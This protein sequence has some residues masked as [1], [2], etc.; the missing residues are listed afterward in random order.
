[1]KA[2]PVLLFVFT[3]S[4]AG[5]EFVVAPGGPY[6]TVQSAVDAAPPHSVVHIRP[7]VYKERVVVPYEKPHLTFRGDDAAGTII[8]FDSHAGLPGP[9]GPI[10]TFATPT[11]FVQADDF[12][13]ENL[14]FENSAG[15]V[16]QAVALTIMGDRGVFRNCRFLGYQDTLLAQ[17]GRQLFDRCYIAG[18]VDFIFGGS[19]AWFER[20]TIHATAGGYLT[21]ANTTRDQPYGFVFN[22]CKITG[23]PGAKTWL[24]RP[25]RPYAATVFFNSEISDVL[26]PEGW[27]NWNDPAREKTVR[28][29]EYPAPATRVPW[30]KA[31]S[32]EEAARFTIES[33]LSGIDG[34]NPQTGAVRHALRI[35][36]SR[37]AHPPQPPPYR[38]VAAGPDG[39]FHAV[40]TDGKRLLH[41]VSRDL[42][43]WSAPQPVDLM[44]GRDALDLQFPNLFY[45]ESAR[46]FIV[47]WSCTLARNAI[48]AF[49]EDVEANPRIWYATTRDFSTYSETALLFDNNYAVAEARILKLVNGYALLHTDSTWPMQNLRVAFGPSPTGPWGPSTGAFTPKGTRAPLAVQ[50]D[51]T[52]WIFHSGGLLETRDFWTF[53]A[54]PDAV[55]PNIENLSL[56]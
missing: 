33:V 21:A 45:D 30:A 50:R 17:A 23:A 42:K 27:N 56:R 53:T 47:T 31:L 11:V 6:P 46:R 32:P 54:H 52:W 36:P 29:A 44:A 25:W 40:S 13:A 9:K 7:G 38:N 4:A 19:A 48:Q 10:N 28:Y 8:T 18:A 22:R 49:Q 16:G 5:R 35:T 3:P 55:P 43:S 39:I 26:R 51:G 20:C 1:M 2:F 41:A 12:T 14:T 24:G 37:A 34:W 15:N